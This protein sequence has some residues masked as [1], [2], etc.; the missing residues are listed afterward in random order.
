MSSTNTVIRARIDQATKRKATA[1]LKAMGL[2]P[3]DAI[4]MLMVRVARDKVLPFTPNA[5]TIAAMEE[6]R[7]GQLK[8]AA[9]VDELIADL[10]ADD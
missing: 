2:S 1:A 9:S 7:R 5:T 8:S 10:H 3:S 4:R 6:A